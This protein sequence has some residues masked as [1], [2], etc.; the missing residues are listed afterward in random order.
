MTPCPSCQEPNR[1]DRRFCTSCGA[2]LVAVCPRCGAQSEPGERFCGECGA[3]LRAGP[4]GP[5]TA[6]SGV[7]D[8]TARRIV[9]ILFADLVGFTAASERRD[10]EDVRELLD[11]YVAAARRIVGHYGGVIEKFIGDAVMAVWGTPLAHEDDAERAV[12]AALDL[13]AAVPNLTVHGR[14]TGLEARA[15]VLTGEA[16]VDLR[17]EGQRM[18][19][20]DTVNTA[21]RLQAVAEPGVVLV[22]E[23]TRLATGD[24]VEYQ[25]AGAHPVKGK[26]LPVR[27]WRAVR[28]TRRRR[29]ETLEPPFVGRDRELRQLVD[30]LHAV[31]EDSR[32]RLV[33]VTGVAGIGKSRLA[34][35]LQRYAA[36]LPEVVYWHEGRCPAYGEGVT[37][38][39]L[40]EMVR[41]RAGLREDDDAATSR[42]ALQRMLVDLLPQDDERRWVQEALEVLL[43]VSERGRT[44]RS[45]EQA[46]WRRFFESVATW[47]PT[48]LVVED[49]HAADEG[50]VRFLEQLLGWS[51][52][53][54]ILVLTLARPEIADRHPT[55]GAAV[56][57]ATSLHLEPL[58]EPAMRALLAGLIPDLSD[59][60]VATVLARA[61]GVPLYAVETV[62]ALLGSEGVTTAAA[63]AALDLPPTLTALVSSR[64]DVLPDEERSVLRAASVLG[65]TFRL[66]TLAHVLSRP[67]DEITTLVERLALRDVLVVYSD[68]RSPERGQYGFVQGLL[69]EV[70]C[71]MLSRRDRRALHLTAAEW[72]ASRDDVALASVVAHH[73]VAAV[74]AD[75]WADDAAELTARARDALLSAAD[76]AEA[77]GALPQAVTFVEEALAF[78]EDKE[79]SST[80]HLRAAELAWHAA[81]GQRTV[82]HAEHAFDS[83]M[84]LRRTNEAARAAALVGI[85]TIILGT[86]RPNGVRLME[87]R[88]AALETEADPAPLAMLASVIASPHAIDG[89]PQ[90][91]LVWAERCLAL[92]GPVDDIESIVT[93]VMTQGSAY[94]RLARA[95][96]GSVLLLGAAQLA[97]RAAL[98]WPRLLASVNALDA[99][100]LLDPSR[101]VDVGSPAVE[102]ARRHGQRGMEVYAAYNT[103]WAALHTGNWDTARSLA[104]AVAEGP[105]SDADQGIR[106]SQALLDLLSGARPPSDI[107][108]EARAN[109]ARGVPLQEAEDW[110]NIDAIAAA[111]GREPLPRRWWEGSYALVAETLGAHLVVGHIALWQG[112]VDVALEEADQVESMRAPGPF[113]KLGLRCLRAGIRALVEGADSTVDE[114]DAVIDGYR[115][116]GL[117]FHQAL[118]QVDRALL[119]DDAAAAVEADAMLTA[120]GAG[121]FLGWLRGTLP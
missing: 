79:T 69:R 104:L 107:R 64:I 82:D 1:P 75:P 74:H 71:G 105:P 77:L 25:S 113:A 111:L 6:A 106:L 46:A 24:A 35:E 8:D 4:T 23:V 98:V 18:V 93:G 103:I 94:L 29:G 5:P 44:D 26:T 43:G 15:G 85:G 86:A 83:Y 81:L 32:A 10:P 53:A 117:R 20:G 7:G 9:T 54:P 37:F 48:I 39:A 115:V 65:Q 38:W 114:Y 73:Y 88:F 19:T 2:P 90:D 76:R 78:T 36:G 11:A 84:S 22:D 57:N 56:R 87:E 119:F 112:Q 110:R 61:E 80:L 58:A 14:T 3:G 13:V 118:A 34:R 63:P 67:M 116:E 72:F 96:E 109:L 30:A 59:E 97:E 16:A 101:A 47:G 91:A 70:A 17:A 21:A 95:R 31:A 102:L 120:L 45:D 62:R 40:G 41:M 108:G 12:R 51:H 33:S 27:A 28:G 99:L 49:L 42:L 89:D 121:P 55:W 92:A 50:L 52:R 100:M 66:D 68:P 60:V